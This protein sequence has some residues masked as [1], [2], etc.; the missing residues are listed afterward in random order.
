M[1]RHKRL[2]WRIFLPF[3][4]IVL[5]SLISMTGYTSHSIKQFLLN[6]TENELKDQALMTESRV[7][8]YLLP[9]DRAGIQQF[10][11]ESGQSVTTRMTIILP[12]GEVVGDSDENP[13]F[14]DDH[15]RRPEVAAALTGQ[16]GTSVRFSGTVSQ[17]MMYLAIPLQRDNDI[18]A[19]LRTAKPITVIEEE[20]NVL[21]K[22]S[23][24]WAGLTILLASVMALIISRR[25]SRPIEAMRIGAA[26][27]ARGE[28]N[29]ALPVPDIRE[30]AS[31]AESMN[32][33]AAQLESRINTIVNQRNEYEPVLTSMIEGVIAVDAEERILSI[34]QA[35]MNM[36][37]IDPIHLKHRSLQ[38]MIRNPELQKAVAIALKEKKSLDRDIVLHHHEDERILNLKC[39]PLSSV[40][41]A[42]I[43]ALLVLN[44]V[45]RMR[46]LE[47]V[48]RD[49][50]AN[51]SHELK[52]PLTTIKGFVET[53]LNGSLIENPIE[54]ER[55]LGIINKHVDRIN[56]IIEDLL[57]LARLERLDEKIAQRFEERDLCEIVEN[58]IQLIHSQ[59][60]AKKIQLELQCDAR[61]RARFETTLIEQALVNLLDNAVKYSPANS[62]V[63]VHVQQDDCEITIGIQDE[64]PGIH[65]KHLPRLFERFYRADKARSRELGGTGLGLAIVKHIAQLHHGRI[66]VETTIGKGSTFTLHLPNVTV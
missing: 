16:V 8:E 1:T 63:R 45:T 59:A 44:D 34:N 27:F 4:L 39:C 50:V 17:N 46:L 7:W 38:E 60:E 21:L 62:Q 11:R 5:I 36:L 33:M 57:S 29:Y 31:L 19:V 13:A 43:G 25:I 47:K 41:K 51:V 56:T 64:G 22:D 12:D 61:P 40:D 54:S 20:L 52:T 14:M 6:Q 18:V 55:F 24:I 49:F 66:S 30:L 48:R 42:K 15:R 28:L 35:A 2:I 65:K 37:N 3:L 53:L 10:C 58:A 26:H 9:V 32:D 23:L